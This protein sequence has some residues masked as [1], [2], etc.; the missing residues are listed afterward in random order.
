MMLKVAALLVTLLVTLQEA[1][2]VLAMG[3]R[4][5]L[6]EKCG[7]DP[8]IINMNIGGEETGTGQLGKQIQD[9][10]EA[11][12]AVV[13]SKLEQQVKELAEGQKDL[14][15]QVKNLTLDLCR[16]KMDCCNKN[17]TCPS[18]YERFCEKPDMCYKFATDEKTY[19]DAK[20]A[21]QAA[22]GHLVMP[23]DQPTNDLL[24]NQIMARYPD[25]L[26]WPWIGLT[27]EAEEGTWVWDDGATLTGT[28]WSNWK[29]GFPRDSTLYNCAFWAHPYNS[30]AWNNGFYCSSECPYICEVKAA[31]VN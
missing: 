17:L 5:S 10:F 26:S 29:E 18:G 1:D 8:P 16:T 21:C 20:S 31:A 23:K 15:I 24:L 7:N 6:E 9:M 11:N 14:Q 3:L 2:R 4:F 27:D 12:Q 25:P 19:S 30:K 22:G 13:I 28:G